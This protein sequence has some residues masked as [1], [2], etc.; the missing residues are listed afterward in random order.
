M[1]FVN[2]GKRR[3][4]SLY[5]SSS[6]DDEE[7]CALCTVAGAINL[8]M[9]RA[10]LSTK[11]VAQ[12]YPKGGMTLGS[13]P[14]EQ[15]QSILWLV[16]DSTL[17]ESDY[18]GKRPYAEAAA[19]MAGFEDG[20]VYAMWI[21]GFLRGNGKS[22]THWLNALK[23][24][25]V[26]RYFDFQ[27][28]RKVA[29]DHASY[30]GGGLNPATALVPICAIATQSQPGVGTSVPRPNLQRTDQY[31]A[32]KPADAVCRVIAFPPRNPTARQDVRTV[33]S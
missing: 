22:C 31:G 6:H 15:I 17:R 20:T 16:E 18:C 32:F 8:T 21:E 33:F 26:V 7:N 27:A 14:D 11:M 28:N 30:S 9:G 24:G 23:A 10:T 19:W 5:Y 12:R 13:T 2:E 25:G 4:Q 29:H 3:G 1:R